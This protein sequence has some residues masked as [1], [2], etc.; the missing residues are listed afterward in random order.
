MQTSY[1]IEVAHSHGWSMRRDSAHGSGLFVFI[2][3]AVLIGVLIGTLCYTSAGEGFAQTMLPVGEDFIRSRLDMDHAG[4]L[5]RSF[6]STS[7]YLGILFILGLCAAGQPFEVAA[8]VF[9]GMGIGLAMSQLYSLYGKSSLLYTIGL[10]LPGAVISLI[11]IALGA[12]EAFTLSCILLRHS[13]SDRS[14]QGLAGT[15][16]LYGAKFLVLEALTALSA[17]A[18]VLCNYLFIY[19]FAVR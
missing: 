3:G 15:I 5:L 6:M 11:A 14:E 10:M 7:A 2:C 12:K 16:R 19:H 1:G 4:I 9:R 17:G 18:D 8:A 13:L